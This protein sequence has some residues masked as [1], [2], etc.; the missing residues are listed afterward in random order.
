[1]RDLYL[2]LVTESGLVAGCSK[3][4]FPVFKRAVQG[5]ESTCAAA[6]QTSWSGAELYVPR[7]LCREESRLLSEVAWLL[8][9]LRPETCL[10]AKVRNHP[11]TTRTSQNVQAVVAKLVLLFHGQVVSMLPQ[12]R[13]LGAAKP[14]LHSG[15]YLTMLTDVTTI[16]HA[17]KERFGEATRRSVTSC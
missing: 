15:I 14:N 16:L 10:P 1:M 6:G 7:Y 2:P 11:R 12:R 17:A 5:L 8:G 4:A 9:A 3:V 13:A